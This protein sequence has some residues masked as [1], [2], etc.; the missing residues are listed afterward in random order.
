MIGILKQVRRGLVDRDR[1]GAGGGVGRLAGVNGES[2]K[3]L[4]LLFGHRDLLQISYRFE[5]RRGRVSQEAA[6]KPEMQKPESCSGS[7]PPGS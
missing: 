2:G 1:A 5:V 3:V 4:F 7:G 6:P